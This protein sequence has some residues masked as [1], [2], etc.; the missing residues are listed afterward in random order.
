MVTTLGGTLIRASHMINIVLV[1]M[2]HKLHTIL[3]VEFESVF[4]L[5]FATE[6]IRDWS[7]EEFF[8]HMM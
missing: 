1:V 4:S 3:Q 6:R 5:V 2:L 7:F 8:C